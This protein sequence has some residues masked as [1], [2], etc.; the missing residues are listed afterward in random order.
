MTLAFTHST[1]REST[2]EPI[3]TEPYSRRRHLEAVWKQS[4]YKRGSYVMCW[5]RLRTDLLDN[6]SLSMLLEISKRLIY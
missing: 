6:R 5:A 1:R 4:L 2:A 3:L